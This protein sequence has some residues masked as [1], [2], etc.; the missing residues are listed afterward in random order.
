LSLGFFW[1]FGFNHRDTEAQRGRTKTLTGAN[2]GN[3]EN[4]KEIFSKMGSS[5]QRIARRGKPLPKPE[6]LELAQRR[7]GRG[8][9]RFSFSLH[10]DLC[11]SPPV[12]TTETLRHSV[13]GRDQ[14][15]PRKTEENEEPQSDTDQKV[16]FV[17]A[18]LCSSVAW[19]RVFLTFGPGNGERSGGALPPPSGSLAVRGASQGKERNP[20]SP[21][22]A[23]AA[24]QSRKS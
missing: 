1:F 18:H 15:S 11:A 9:N 24:A 16:S 7:G 19:L 12:L 23:R 6:K 17:C 22:P 4:E 20:P 2:G 21:R 3:G 8:E 5:R 10:G 14:I 13:A